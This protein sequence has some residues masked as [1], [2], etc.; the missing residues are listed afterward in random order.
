MYRRIV[1]REKREATVSLYGTIGEE[2][3]GNQVALDIAAM[4]E[5]VDTINILVN[6]NGGDVLQ[7]L[8]IVSAILSAKAFIHARVNGI[9]A[10]MAAVITVAADRVTMQD[11]AKLMVHDP[12][13]AGTE[14]GKMTGKERKALESVA[15]TLRTILSRRGCDKGKIAKLMSDETWFTADEAKA[16]G[17]ADEVVRTGRKE[18]YRGL[19]ASEILNKAMSEKAG[20]GV[21]NQKTK[22]MNEIAK[23]LGLPEDATEGQ[24]LNAIQKVKKEN[25]EQRDAAVAALM[26]VGER[27]GVVT[28]K[29]KERMARLAAADLSLFIDL[30]EDGAARPQKKEQAAGGQAGRLSRLSDAITLMKDKGAQPPKPERSWDWYQRND[31]QALMEM[32]RNDLE[33]FNRLLDEYEQSI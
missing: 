27:K 24:I 23:A 25:E 10:S 21:N 19:S 32:E 17:L 11:Y 29:N 16:A 14:G 5:H 7:G 2:V 1:D 15:D 4:D 9:A 8:S 20:M 30:M 18:E 33:R 26:A 22:R 6:S 28:E 12:F 13:Y 3:P 31:P